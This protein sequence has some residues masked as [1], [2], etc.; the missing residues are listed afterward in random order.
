MSKP[1]AY[2]VVANRKGGGSPDDLKTL[3]Q[4]VV[5]DAEIKVNRVSGE[6]PKMVQITAPANSI[7]PLRQKFGDKLIIEPDSPLQLS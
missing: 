1:Q 2:V 7:G 6:P 4:E 3:L 5:K